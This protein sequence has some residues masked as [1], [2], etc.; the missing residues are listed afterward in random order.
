MVEKEKAKREKAERIARESALTQTVV[1]S[2]GGA[3]NEVFDATVVP[4]QQ[5]K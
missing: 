5:K 3:A 4:N 2:T 1:Y